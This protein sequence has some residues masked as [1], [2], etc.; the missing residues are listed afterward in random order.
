MNDFTTTSKND[1]I[2]VNVGTVE[3]F[4]TLIKFIDDK[5]YEYYIYRLKNEKDIFAIIRT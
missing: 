5:K 2:K 4:R 1:K 3:D